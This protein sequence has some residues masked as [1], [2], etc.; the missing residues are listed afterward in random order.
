MFENPKVSNMKAAFDVAKYDMVWVCDSNARSDLNALENAVEIFEND[1][2]VGVVHHLIWAVDANTIGGAIETAF[3]NSTHAR[4]YL[5]I[6]SLKLDSCLTGKSNFYRISSLEKFGGIAA[7]GKYI[8]ED[9]MIG[10]K[11]WRD[12]LAHRM[13]YNLALTSVKGM[14]LS[15]YFKRRIRWVR[16]R[17]CT[18]PGAVLLEPFTESVVVGV[19]TSLALNSLYGVPKAQFLIWHFL[20]WFISDFMLFLRQRKQTEGGIPKLSMQLILSYFIRELSALPVWI[21]GISGNTASWRDKLYK[22]NF[23]GSINAM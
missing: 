22:I 2:S 20:L 16:V 5:A 4:M 17:V 23:D 19:L 18:V 11:L 14:S 13:T 7:F 3:L 9:N 1:S 8:A 6:N 12:G 15:S 10:Q 21:I